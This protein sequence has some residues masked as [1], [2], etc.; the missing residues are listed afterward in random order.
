MNHP[1]P[2]Y[3]SCR[4][5]IPIANS[6]HLEKYNFQDEFHVVIY[7]LTDQTSKI[8]V[9]RLDQDH[10]W[11]LD[12]KIKI[13]DVKSENWETVTIGSSNNNEVIIEKNMKTIQLAPK[14]F[15]EQKIPKRIIQTHFSNQYLS[16]NHYNAIQTFLEL[17][18]EYEYE[19]FNDQDCRSFIQLNYD[20]SILNAYDILIPGAYRSDFFRVCY[21]FK[22]GG[23][24]FDNKHILRIPLSEIIK[25]NDLNFYCKDVGSDTR[26]HNGIF[27]SVAG[28]QDLWALIKEMTKKINHRNRGCSVFDLTGPDIFYQ[29]TKYKNVAFFP[30]HDFL[31]DDKFK[32]RVIY[33]GKTVVIRS[34]KGYYN[35]N[36]R[37]TNYTELWE[38]KILFYENYQRFDNDYIGLT[39]P[40][41]RSWT[42]EIKH[43]RISTSKRIR[44]AHYWIEKIHHVELVRD[45]FRIEKLGNK[46]LKIT[47]LN[48][49][50]WDI[51]L[52]IRIINDKTNEI[53]DYHVGS[54]SHKVKII[55]I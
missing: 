24:Y 35:S 12:L 20:S 33:Q 18:P 22:K 26:N 7:Y 40:E 1:I 31:S 10:G 38:K 42:Q 23:C 51:N 28:D 16:R 13:K 11:G 17:N 9:R 30:N 53:K 4:K 25:P 15:L 2:K 19:Y 8:I 29:F 46:E 55:R 36:H 49:S 45:R 52:S 47:R 37:A 14:T 5:D 50:N 32:Q 3:L 39:K 48:G 34:Y 6:F 44:G 21:I 41:S 27:F 54:S 43:D